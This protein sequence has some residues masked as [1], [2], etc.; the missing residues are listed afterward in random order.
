MILK[1]MLTSA[2]LS[3]LAD[4][5]FPVRTQEMLFSFVSAAGNQEEQCL[6]L[7]CLGV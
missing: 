2:L 1:A 7:Q 4:E 3:W 5:A 6:M